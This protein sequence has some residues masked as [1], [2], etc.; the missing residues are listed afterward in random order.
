MDLFGMEFRR[1]FGFRPSPVR[2]MFD[3]EQELV[4]G[5]LRK[6]A[7]YF[8]RCTETELRI[9]AQKPSRGATLEETRKNLE[10]HEKALRNATGAVEL[11][12]RWFWQAHRLALRQGYHVRARYTDYLPKEVR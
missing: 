11:Y 5:V 1:T 4:D 10:A 2:G 7:G 9:R 12:K 3:H 8:Y 6:L